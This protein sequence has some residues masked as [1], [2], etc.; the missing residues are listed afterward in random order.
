MKPV[1][2]AMVAALG[3]ASAAQAADQPV[4][5]PL[6]PRIRTVQYDPDQVVQLRGWFGFQQMIEFAPDERIENVSIGDAMGWQVTPNKRANILFLKPIDRS[7]VTNMTVVTNLR[8]Y[9]FDLVVATERAR[10][11]AMAY[12]VRFRYP[13]AGPVQVVEVE[14]PA[15]QAEV[16][17]P[18]S[19]N[20]AYTYTGSKEI[21]PSKVFD[22]GRSTFFSWPATVSVPGIFAVGTEGGE[23]LVNYAV[24]GQYLVVDQISPRFVLRSGKSVT[25]VVNDAFAIPQGGPG[26]P[27]PAA[28]KKRGLRLGLFK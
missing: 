9:A 13:Q 15:P 16:I 6:D 5:G 3:V 25:T 23:S 20:F 14:P 19:W 28:A 21:L 22:D 7:A 26:S 4:P 2:L 8:R 10:P 24:R 11:D 17:G 12:V 27:Q 18:E 1:T